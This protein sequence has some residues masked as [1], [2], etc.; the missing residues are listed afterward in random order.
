MARVFF[1]RERLDKET[2]DRLYH[3]VGLSYFE[4]AERFGTRS[5][6]VIKLM[7]QY[8][9]QRRTRCSRKRSR[10]TAD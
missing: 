10:E 6:N 2:L 4:I 5:A 9:I 1:L 8:G 7:D 3:D